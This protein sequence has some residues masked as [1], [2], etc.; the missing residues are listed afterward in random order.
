MKTAKKISDSVIDGIV[1][2]VGNL[3]SKILPKDNK[4][5]YTSDLKNDYKINLE[6]KRA[7][8]NV[9]MKTSKLLGVLSFIIIMVA[10][11][12]LYKPFVKEVNKENGE[13][14]KVIEHKLVQKSEKNNL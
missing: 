4:D 10:N 3:C 14:A 2:V 8:R 7:T 12:N 6:L 1:T 9:T 5:K 13:E 11:M